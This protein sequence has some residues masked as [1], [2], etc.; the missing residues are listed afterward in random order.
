MAGFKFPEEELCQI[1]Y[2][3]HILLPLSLQLQDQFE[4]DKN[5]ID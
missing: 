2:E 3:L 4:E 1:Y 5:S